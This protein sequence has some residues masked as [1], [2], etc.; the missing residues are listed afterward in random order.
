VDIE[1]PIRGRHLRESEITPFDGISTTCLGVARAAS[2]IEIV[3]AF[4]SGT[5]APSTFLRR[6]ASW[7]HTMQS[8]FASCS[9]VASGVGGWPSPTWQLPQTSQ[10]PRMLTQ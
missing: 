8:M 6:Y 3:M 10:F 9:G 5:K 4:S 2:S 1:V 7:W